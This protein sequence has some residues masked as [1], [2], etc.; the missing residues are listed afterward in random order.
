MTAGRGWLA[1]DPHG[2]LSTRQQ[3]SDPGPWPGDVHVV[4]Q[5]SIFIKQKCE[6]PEKHAPPWTHPVA[7]SLCPSVRELTQPVP[8]TT[9]PKALSGEE[10]MDSKSEMEESALCHPSSV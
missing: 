1:A 4:V 5:L 7:P 6:R 2:E 8:R 9:C 3:S 10:G